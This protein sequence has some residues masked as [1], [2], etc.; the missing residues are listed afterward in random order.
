[1][2]DFMSAASILWLFITAGRAALLVFGLAIGL[3]TTHR[4]R[5]NP[6]AQRLTDA[7]TREQYRAEEKNAP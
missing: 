7:A 2:E 5:E 1:M 4:R 3:L 6:I